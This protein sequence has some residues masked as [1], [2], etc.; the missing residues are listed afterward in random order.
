MESVE[1]NGVRLAYREAG[2]PDGTPAV[3]LHGSGSSSTTWDRFAPRLTG[4]RTIAVDLRGHG[5]SG[6]PGDYSLAGLRDDLLGLLQALDLRD[7]L[8]VG[9][10]VGAYIALAAAAEVPE[11]IA[12]LVLEDL[13]APPRR[14]E[15]V[16]GINPFQV[17]AAVAGIVSV[18]RDY[19]L[20]ALASL[21]SQLTRPDLAW[22]S[23]LGAARQPTLVLSGGPTSCIPPR[24]L[25]EAVAEMHDARL[26]T[27][28]VGHR[29]HSLAPD[30]FATEVLSFLTA[31]AHSVPA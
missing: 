3:L 14:A 1:I 20:R 7:A 19:D 6:R 4:H 29:V 25:A 11:R 9:H 17:L 16:R 31:T 15:R 10:S 28:P 2:D 27:I 24:R 18:R 22:W 21:L 23:R 13:A 12:R 30:R 5:A 8:V 26:A